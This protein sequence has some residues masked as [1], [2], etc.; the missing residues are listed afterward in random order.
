MQQ[1]YYDPQI[2]RMLSVDPVATNPNTGANF[3]RYSF[4][5]DNP[6]R[7]TDPDGRYA[8]SGKGCDQV[9]AAYDATKSAVSAMPAGKERATAQKALDAI[10]PK[11]ESGA[12]YVM[13]SIEGNVAAKYDWTSNKTTVD[14]SKNASVPMLGAAMGH[15]VKHQQDRNSGKP[16]GTEKQFRSL[17][18][19][20]YGVTQVILNAFG[21][22]IPKPQMNQLIEDSVKED[23]KSSTTVVPFLGAHP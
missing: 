1:R 21:L 4:A 10:G 9:D 3:S 2:G 22:G 17:E 15:E 5:N 13:G 6:Y 12:I 20:A 11:G 23:M 16:S 7:F 8:C 14:L 18:K 19:S